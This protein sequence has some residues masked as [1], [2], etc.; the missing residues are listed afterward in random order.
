MLLSS[1]RASL[2]PAAFAVAAALMT[3]RAEAGPPAPAAKTAKEILQAVMD[4]LKKSKW[5]EGCERL[6]ELMEPSRLEELRKKD[7]AAEARVHF[8]A[9][10]CHEHYE[11]YGSAYRAYKAVPVESAASDVRKKAVKLTVK[12]PKDVEVVLIELDGEPLVTDSQEP[13][14]K[15]EHTLKASR[16]DGAVWQKRITI[17]SDHTVEIGPF[18]EPAAPK[19]DPADG[20]RQEPEVPKQPVRPWQRPLGIAVGAAGLASAALGSVFGGL[21]IAKA[22]PEKVCRP[23]APDGS[24]DACSFADASTVTLAVGGALLAGGAVL[25]FTAPAADKGKEARVELR[26]GGSFLSLRGEF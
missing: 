5:D 21:A 26:V 8:N 25:L 15:G 11:R 2:V 24:G 12:T 1:L 23:N 17:E 20:P 18:P 14:D 19:A 10:R 7:P 22:N 16:K 4:D 3:S 6:Q 9:G 13:V